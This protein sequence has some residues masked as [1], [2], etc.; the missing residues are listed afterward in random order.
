MTGFPIPGFLQ[1]GTLSCVL[2]LSLVLAV[3]PVMP[4]VA[5]PA[6]WWVSPSGNDVTGTGTRSAPYRTITEALT[7][8]VDGDAIKVLPGVYDAAAGEVFPLV[9]PTGVDLIG[10][11]PASR[12]FSVMGRTAS[13]RSPARVS[14]KSAVWRSPTVVPLEASCGAAASSCSATTRPTASSS[15]T[16]GSTTVRRYG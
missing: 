1:R 14:L 7:H 11:G 10:I 13:S 12:R 9:L 8:G 16:A 15:K 5:A 4:A 3:T 6:T 2:V